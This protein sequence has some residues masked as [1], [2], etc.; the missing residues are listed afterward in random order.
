MVKVSVNKLQIA[1]INKRLFLRSFSFRKKLHSSFKLIWQPYIVLI[2]KSKPFAIGFKS[3][4]KEKIK[5]SDY[6]CIFSCNKGKFLVFLALQAFPCLLY[7]IPSNKLTNSKPDLSAYA[8][9]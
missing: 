8:A 3:L 9:V 5:A 2:R 4:L 7:T 6:P 1:A